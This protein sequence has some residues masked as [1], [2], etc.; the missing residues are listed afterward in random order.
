MNYMNDQKVASPEAIKLHD[1]EFEFYI[2]S[3][4]IA[5][6]VAEIGAK[7]NTD[8]AGKNPLFVGVLNG[9]FL[10]CADI[11]KHVTIDCDMTFVRVSSYQGTASSGAV[12]SVFGLNEMV[13]N[14]NIVF[15]EDIL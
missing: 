6:K 10:F 5:Q 7:I 12:K 8:M 11:F 1:K 9:A 2:S 3:A 13:T 14:R 4:S 15:V